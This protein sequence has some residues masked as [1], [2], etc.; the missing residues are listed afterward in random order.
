MLKSIK[1]FLIL[2]HSIIL[3]NSQH[4]YF[5]YIINRAILQWLPFFFFN[6]C[7]CGFLLLALLLYAWYLKN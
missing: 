3:G 6:G 7:F 1:Y 5:I 2:N 4:S